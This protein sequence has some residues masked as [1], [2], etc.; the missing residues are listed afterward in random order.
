MSTPPDRASKGGFEQVRAHVAHY[1]DTTTKLAVLMQT[2]DP[3]ESEESRKL[4]DL[5]VD[6]ATLLSG[7]KAQ[8]SPAQEQLQAAPSPKDLGTVRVPSR[9][10]NVC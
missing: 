3:S 7:T 2:F 6:C 1:V 5:T 4:Y 8:Q 10:G 9:E